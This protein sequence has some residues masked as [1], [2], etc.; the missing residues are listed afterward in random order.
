MPVVAFVLVYL[1]A[2][3]LSLNPWISWWG[4]YQRMQGTY[5]TLSYV[6]FFLA[7]LSFY[8]RDGQ[9]YRL[10]DA[11]IITSVP[12]CLYGI[13]QRFELDPVPWGGDV[14]IRIAANMGNS[15]FLGA[16][17]VMVVPLT[18]GRIISN[19]QRMR[20]NTGSYLPKILSTGFLVFSGIIQLLA[21]YLSGSRGPLLGLLSGCFF[22]FV[23]LSLYWRKRKLLFGTIIVAASVG[24]FLFFVN[25]PEGPLEDVRTAPWLGRLGQVFDTEQRTSKVR[26]LIWNGAAELVS[27]H[28]PLEYPDGRAD[29]FN[30]IRPVIGY[31][32]ESMYVAYSRFYPPELGRLERRNAIPDRSHNETWDA[33]VT[34]GVVGFTAYM[35]VFAALF[36]HTLKWLGILG[37]R[38]NTYIFYSLY[39]LGGV[40][41]AIALG[42]WQGIGFMGVGLPI[43]M[44]LG[45][46]AYLA[47]YSLF[48]QETSVGIDRDRVILLV[49]LLSGVVAHFVEIHF[50][51]AIASTRLY[52]WVMMGLM[53]VIG[54][55]SVQ[56]EHRDTSSQDGMVLPVRSGTRK[57]SRRPKRPIKSLSIPIYWQTTPLKVYGQGILLGILLATLGF[58]YVSNLERATTASGIL[59]NSLTYLPAQGGQTMYGIL[60]LCLTTWV[61]CAIHLGTSDEE[62][63][64]DRQWMKN[65]LAILIVSGL[66]GA[67][68]W[69]IQSY[70]L[71]KLGNFLPTSQADVLVHVNQYGNLVSYY[72]LYIFF[73]L[74]FLGLCLR[75]NNHLQRSGVNFSTYLIPVIVIPTTLV[76]IYAS[77]IRPIQ[78]DIAFKLTEPFIRQNQY[79]MAAQ[80]YE[81]A[82]EKAPNEDQYL[83]FLG[84]GYME[85]ARLMQTD[86]EREAILVQSE[87]HLLT[88][89]SLNPLNTDHTTNLARLYAWWSANH[90]DPERSGQL[91]WQADRYYEMA[92]NLSP[93]HASIWGE[94]AINRMRQLNDKETAL[95]L[96][97]SALHIDPEFDR[98]YAVLGDYY[99]YTAINQQ[100][101]ILRESSLR[102]AL[103]QYQIALDL[104]PERD[105]TVQTRL[106][107]LGFIATLHNELQEF[108]SAIAVYQNALDFATPSEAWRLHEYLARLFYQLSEKSNASAHL[109]EAMRSAPESDQ[110]RLQDLATQIQALP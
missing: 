100:D 99:L 77:N 12:I 96:I 76:L 67:S 88:A 87:E 74:L 58:N 23:L 30:L 10:V 15:I 86:D 27:P 31:G 17:L 51:I 24:L 53:V 9:I 107:Y 102:N 81:L 46:I 55:R 43:G 91:A 18:F 101:A 97:E 50:G 42:A 73:A 3:L 68:Y 6:I 61:L 103:A 54:Q 5:T 32:P 70:L 21:I 64:H 98:T 35:W 85:Y 75:A 2:T 4:S 38:K 52:F 82:L 40:L 105:D 59:W 93:N 49:A 65:I 13:L 7:I 71:A 45:S 94:R 84:R 108:S 41:S 28:K 106:L 33:L 20:I 14:S 56:A 62:P 48:K 29:R 83:L 26:S 11:I 47:F 19:F 90:G 69:Y 95:S 109:E 78:A 66:L 22:L 36:Y 34:T 110:Q 72:F 39:F 8:R 1:L 104:L 92:I 89:Q 79:L 16:Y 57:D 60:F 80:I 63:V 37:S 25:I 44:I